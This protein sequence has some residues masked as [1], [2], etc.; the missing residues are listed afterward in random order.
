MVVVTCAT[1]TTSMQKPSRLQS[2]LAK[3]GELRLEI[4]IKSREEWW[5]ILCHR[6]P[7]QSYAFVDQKSWV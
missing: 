4:F 5:M 3:Q 6:Q 7:M 1:K 2:F